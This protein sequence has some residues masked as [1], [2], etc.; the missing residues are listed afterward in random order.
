M[1]QQLC[2]A[3]FALEG[4]GGSGVRGLSLR[5]AQQQ[6]FCQRHHTCACPQ[7]PVL[8]CH[9]DFCLPFCCFCLPMC[10]PLCVSQAID[11]KECDV[12]SYKSD[13]ETDP[14]GELLS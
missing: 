13:G 9:G 8:T 7:L 5:T 1:Q 2:V 10:V 14:F 12:Y 3:A 11:L 6:L 4:S